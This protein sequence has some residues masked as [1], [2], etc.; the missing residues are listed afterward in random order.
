MDQRFQRTIIS[1]DDSVCSCNFIRRNVRY[2]GYGYA[3]F[4][5]KY[6]IPILL[7][8]SFRSIWSQTMRE[9]IGSFSLTI[10]ELFSAGIANERH[11]A[12]MKRLIVRSR[13]RKCDVIARKFIGPYRPLVVR[14]RVTERDISTFLST[15]F[16]VRKRA[17][18]EHEKKERKKEGTLVVEKPTLSQRRHN[19]GTTIERWYLISI[20]DVASTNSIRS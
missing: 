6:S 11:T 19:Y 15:D 2:A 1:H 18:T 17:K 13:Y 3:Q 14:S 16:S 5:Y 8:N 9:S 12:R 10:R 7:E 20:E 4:A